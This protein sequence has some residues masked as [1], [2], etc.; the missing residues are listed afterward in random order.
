MLPHIIARLFSSLVPD[1]RRYSAV[2]AWQKTRAERREKGARTLDLLLGELQVEHVDGV[3]AKLILAHPFHL[4]RHLL[5]LRLRLPLL[6]PRRDLQ[7]RPSTALAAASAASAASPTS[8]TGEACPL[9]VDGRWAWHAFSRTHRTHRTHRCTRQRPNGVSAQQRTQRHTRLCGL[10]FR[11]WR[12]GWVSHLELHQLAGPQRTQ[13]HPGRHT[14]RRLQTLTTVAAP[15]A[16]PARPCPR[17]R[18]EPADTRPPPPRAASWS[19]WRAARR[20]ALH[21]TRSPPRRGT[22]RPPPPHPCAGRAAVRAACVM[23]GDR[24]GSSLAAACSLPSLDVDE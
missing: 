23:S 9:H 24:A 13:L 1:T 21:G 6:P 17:R 18:C 3:G 5:V 20:R 7:P 15:P 14:P 16:S 10:G 8:P 11:W 22:A 4:L 19:A 12:L 2:S